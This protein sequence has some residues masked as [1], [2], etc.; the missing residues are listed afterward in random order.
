MSQINSN[1]L[2]GKVIKNKKKSYIL[3]NKLGSGSFATVWLCYARNIKKL[4]AIKIFKDGEHRSGQKEI[5]TY[6]RFNKL[7]IRNTIKMYD[8]FTHNK[9]VYIVL[10]L[11]FGSL[12]DIMKKGKCG[13]DSYKNGY[14]IEFSKK[15]IPSLLLCLKDLH[16]NNIIH[17]DIKPENILIFGRTIQHHNLL[18]KLLIKTSDRRIS[19]VIKREMKNVIIIDTS[20]S[21]D[22][23]TESDCSDSD[24]S[25]H[26]TNCSLMSD[27]PEPIELT[28]SE[29]DK[30][31]EK[32]EKKDTI[33]SKFIIPFRYI[34]EPIVKLSDLGSCIFS[35]N[36]NKPNNIQ[37]KYYRSP[38]I[39]IGLEYTTASDLWALGCTLYELVTGEILFNPDNRT[40]IDDKR[41][42]LSKI[43]NTI[44][45]LPTELINRSPLKQVFFTDNNTLKTNIY[46]KDDNKNI[47]LKLCEKGIHFSIVSVICN[48]LKVNPSERFA[49]F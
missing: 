33:D 28:D 35:D 29:Q 15:I 40:D 43:Y 45:P 7:G 42:I 24:I 49:V 5:E 36:K 2:K 23:I 34:E 31:N 4:M 20:D 44:G 37:T 9:N 48:L 8:N 21:D 17:G 3:V 26:E 41:Y 10:E 39:I 19:E 14:P 30:S 16:K 38:E 6:E 46:D 27:D 1:I 47:F 12:Y 11:M 18:K 22:D 13:N 25:K 32:D